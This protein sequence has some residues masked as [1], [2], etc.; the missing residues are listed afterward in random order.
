MSSSSRIVFRQRPRFGPML[1]RGIC[2]ASATS[3]YS[4]RPGQHGEP[5]QFLA[6]LRK[7]AE[8][9]PQPLVAFGAQHLGLRCRFRA[10]H[11]LGQ[12]VG[13]GH[14]R[15]LAATHPLRLVAG[16]DHQPACQRFRFPQ[17]VQMADQRQPHGLDH[18][19]GRM[20]VQT[21]TTR[22]VPHER[23]QLGDQTV[24]GLSVARAGSLQAGLE[25]LGSAESLPGGIRLGG[26]RF[27]H[28]VRPH[29]GWFSS[30]QR[31]PVSPARHRA[32][33]GSGGQIHTSLVRSS[34]GQDERDGA[35]RLHLPRPRQ[36]RPEQV[37]AGPDDV[38][39]QPAHAPLAR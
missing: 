31:W 30:G 32:E 35:T 2:S 11:G 15:R 19:L 4:A 29:S 14:R 16:R 36:L 22:D 33:D 21:L 8:R 18:V 26:P 25:Q 10:L 28:R 20:R 38:E 7:P 6:P 1:P 13:Q 24:Q 5:Q 39:C 34:H 17:P 37:P 23:R 9:Q 27:R 12:L 3:R